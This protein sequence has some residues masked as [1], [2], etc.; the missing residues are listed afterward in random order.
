MALPTQ[1]YLKNPPLEESTLLPDPL[2]EFQRW[3]DAATAAGMIEPTAM[4]LATASPD[5][6]PSARIVLFKG[7]HEGRFTFYTDYR[8][9]KG[10]ELDANPRAALTFWWDRLE[11]QVRIEGRV[12]RLPRAVSAA[13][14]HSRP[15]GS[16]VGA[17][18]SHQSRVLG[19]RAELD[20]RLEANLR[21]WED[22]REI[23]LPE[24]W[25]G[26]GLLPD[27]LEFWQGRGNRLH[28]RL[29]YRRTAAGW[30]LERLEP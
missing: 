8:G 10:R 22:G 23:P 4:T 19:S 13:Y 16:Q 12:E 29:R 5:G 1:Q 18:T 27:S 11:R 30:Q 26:Y 9:R 6:Q 15:R 21:H 3:L 24:H 25:G 14:F 20:A 28:D 7:F 17:L 2:A